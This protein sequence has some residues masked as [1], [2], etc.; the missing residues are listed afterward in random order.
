MQTISSYRGNRP[1]HTPTNRQDQ[2]QYTVLQLACSVI[3]HITLHY[4]AAVLPTNT[5]TISLNHTVYKTET[6]PSVELEPKCLLLRNRGTL[7]LH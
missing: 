6:P 4:T 2:L 7:T 3:N 5:L 1:P